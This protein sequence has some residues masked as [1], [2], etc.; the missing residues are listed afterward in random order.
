MPQLTEHR[1]SLDIDTK[2]GVKR[3]GGSMNEKHQLYDWQGRDWPSCSSCFYLILLYTEHWKWSFLQKQS[4]TIL[5]VF[6][7]RNCC[8]ISFQFSLHAW[9]ENHIKSMLRDVSMRVGKL[10]WLATETL[11][12]SLS[13]HSPR[14][15]HDLMRMRIW[16]VKQKKYVTLKV[17]TQSTIHYLWWTCET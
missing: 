7:P 10:T 8:H 9:I 4:I 16:L 12:P 2:R 13:S 1:G 17:R 14:S 5:L 15:R 11:H 3:R 6:H